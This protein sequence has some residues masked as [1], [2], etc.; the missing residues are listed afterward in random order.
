MQ[1]ILTSLLILSL[2][3]VPMAAAAE[4]SQSGSGF[5]AGFFGDCV[6]VTV[7]AE[8]GFTLTSP[9]GGDWDIYFNDDAGTASATLGD[10]SGTVPAGA[11][12]A[13]VC[14]WSSETAP[15][16]GTGA[17]LLVVVPGETEFVYTDG[18]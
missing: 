8:T 13:D 1:R 18:L 16:T 17:E 6:T 14:A 12:E 3:A 7:Q 15:E 2:M 11:T 10:E 4:N 5:A 9:D